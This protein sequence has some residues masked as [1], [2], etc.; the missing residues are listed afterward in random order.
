MAPGSDAQ[1]G[2]YPLTLQVADHEIPFQ[3]TIEPDEMLDFKDFHLIFT[4][5]E[6][7]GWQYD[8]PEAIQANYSL[9]IAPY[10][11]PLEGI[12]ELTQTALV[13]RD[14][15]DP[16]LKAGKHYVDLVF[17]AVSGEQMT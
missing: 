7:E 4:T 9:A 10:G 15:S 3:V 13:I 11:N 14:L 17:T 16:A 1:P 5:A 12:L 6:E 2:V 8:I